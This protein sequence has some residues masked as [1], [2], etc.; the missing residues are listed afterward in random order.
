MTYYQEDTTYSVRNGEDNRSR[1]DDW[2]SKSYVRSSSHPG[3]YRTASRNNYVRD[4]SSFWKGFQARSGSQ[5]GGRFT[6]AG[7]NAK[8]GV[9]NQSISQERPKS[10]LFGKV[11]NL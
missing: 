6:G 3:Y 1:R 4:N 11:E 10:E 5:S 9:R 8:Q 2:N 7:N